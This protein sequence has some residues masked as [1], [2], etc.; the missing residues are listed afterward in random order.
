[1]TMSAVEQRLGAIL[2]ADWQREVELLD[3]GK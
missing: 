3:N 2:E 1:M